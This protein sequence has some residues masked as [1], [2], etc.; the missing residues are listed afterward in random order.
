[1]S[2][3]CTRKTKR[4]VACLLIVFIMAISPPTTCCLDDRALQVSVALAHRAL[5]DSDGAGEAG[6]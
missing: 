3:P 5:E 4:Q 6:L 2:R 1:M